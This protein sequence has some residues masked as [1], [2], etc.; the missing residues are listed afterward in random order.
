M[1]REKEKLRHIHEVRNIFQQTSF[2][3]CF[4]SS[5][6]QNS[7]KSSIFN[8]DDLVLNIVE[9]VGADLA[10]LLRRISSCF[11]KV[12]C[13]HFSRDACR[14][15]IETFC[16]SVKLISWMIADTNCP[17][18]TCKKN[19]IPIVAESKDGSPDVLAW[20]RAQEPPFE[21][22]PHCCWAAACSGNL[23]ALVWLLSQDP[24]C[25]SENT[26]SCASDNALLESARIGG[27]IPVLTWLCT[28]DFM[29]KSLYREYV[30]DILVGFFEMWMHGVASSNLLVSAMKHS[31]ENDSPI[32]LEAVLN[33]GFQIFQTALAN[34]E[35]ALARVDIQGIISLVSAVIGQKQCDAA[36]VDM[37]I[38]TLELLISQY[39]KMIF[40]MN[41]M[42]PMLQES[43]DILSRS[44]AQFWPNATVPIESDKT[45]EMAFSRLEVLSDSLPVTVLSEPVL[46]MFFDYMGSDDAEKRKGGCA[47]IAAVAEGCTDA[48]TPVGS[49]LISKLCEATTDPERSV[50][51]TALFALLQCCEHCSRTVEY[52]HEVIFRSVCAVL[53]LESVEDDE[54]HI[55]CEVL[56]SLCNLLGSTSIS[57][58]LSVIMD[59]LKVLI[60]LENPV[61]SEVAL[62]ALCGV[63]AGA[64][65][66]F[67][68]YVEVILFFTV[69]IST[70][71]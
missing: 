52:N 69:F 43:V 35:L 13:V 54:R 32:E 19:C 15:R 70:Y 26:L 45:A 25:P 24:P 14:A 58:F 57:P 7:C 39:S 21:W 65:K 10:C 64:E 60:L 59:H 61:T 56:G 49:H 46:S 38:A 51:E 50:R 67:A 53:A 17:V 62:S 6:R 71:R 55:S 20:C 3:L 47:L 48:F 63:A 4:S 11:N 2:V 12:M 9:F 44:S 37:A 68:P 29:P 30:D 27:Q 16:G 40:K 36:N 18:H 5:I 28:H 23:P 42:R 31:V 1:E 33:T 34:G 41:L 66:L 22:G 8:V